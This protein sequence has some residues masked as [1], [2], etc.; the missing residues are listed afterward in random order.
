M[1]RIR[2]KCKDAVL[3]GD[4]IGFGAELRC[5]ELSCRCEG[6]FGGLAVIVFKSG[7]G[8]I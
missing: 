7:G 5:E 8:G 2:F 4:A 1:F 6:I 3:G